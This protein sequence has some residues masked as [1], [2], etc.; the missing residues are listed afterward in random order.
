MTDKEK[1]NLSIDLL[2]NGI[3][4]VLKGIDELFDDESILKI[5]V[6]P[7]ELNLSNFKYGILHVF[8]GFLL[9]L[10]ERLYRHLPE[11]IF[12]GKISEVR[13]KV[14]NGRVPNTVDL[15]EILER[16][17]IGPLV[18]FPEGDLEIIRR[19][20]NFRNQFEHYKVDIN[21]FELWETITQFLALVDKFLVD[22]LEINLDS[23]ATT[24]SVYEK[25]QKIELHWERIEKRK[26]TEI[27]NELKNLR[28]DFEENRE[29]IIKDL[30]DEYYASKGYIERFITCPECYEET[31][32]V[33]GE[34]T[35]ICANKEC[36]NITPIATCDRCGTKMPGYSWD[37]NFCESCEADFARE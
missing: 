3:D 29:S 4:F 36:S 5:S 25:I 14:K 33:F 1:T 32:I 34:Y 28:E 9:L 22:E 8:S 13:E 2:E 31:L 30:E 10:K 17:Q 27:I 35:G 11:L 24:H 23:S 26:K 20:Q 15:D 7:T 16:L 37:V 19:M 21:K 12:K 18:T 6:D